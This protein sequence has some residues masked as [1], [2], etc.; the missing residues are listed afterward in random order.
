MKSVIILICKTWTWTSPCRA[1][2]QFWMYLENKGVMFICMAML[3]V[4]LRAHL[5][6]ISRISQCLISAQPNICLCLAEI[7]VSFVSSHLVL[8]PGLMELLRCISVC[9]PHIY[10]FFY[11][12]A[13]W[14]VMQFLR[15]LVRY[16]LLIHVVHQVF[17]GPCVWGGVNK[18]RIK[19]R[20]KWTVQANME[21][22]QQREFEFIKTNW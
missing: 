9:L 12:L 7:R 19:E 3:R 11:T 15:S 13:T 16:F 20:R 21:I 17:T 14:S 8:S 6:C 4:G 22:I 2:P 1:I 10:L 5:F 18:G